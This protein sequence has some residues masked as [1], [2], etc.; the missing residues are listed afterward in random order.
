MYPEV[1]LFLESDADADVVAADDVE[2]QHNATDIL[3]F[4]A[5]W[6]FKT[7]S[8]KKLYLGFVVNPKQGGWD[9]IRLEV[10]NIIS[11]VFAH[12]QRDRANK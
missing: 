6:N 4:V 9:W 12:R 10:N 5:L 8:G 3:F 7:E 11:Y 1:A 2:R